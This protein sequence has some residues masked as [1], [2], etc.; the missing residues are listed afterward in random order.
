MDMKKWAWIF[1]ALIILVVI[2]LVMVLI[3]PLNKS[4]SL[5]KDF[6]LHIFEDATSSGA[7]R[8][9][10]MFITF[11]NN[12]LVS[13]N[14]KIFISGSSGTFSCN[15]TYNILNDEWT[16]VGDNSTERCDWSSQFY[17]SRDE[18]LNAIRSGKIV[19]CVPNPPYRYAICYEII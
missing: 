8:F 18:V 13:A 15:G 2:I 12:Q 3:F 11:E 6:T 17:P 7:S 14:S 10:D 19:S 1:L 4:P 16:Y 5:P 9:Y